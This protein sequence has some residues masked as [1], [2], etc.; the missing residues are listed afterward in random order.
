MSK[1]EWERLKAGT[2]AD[3]EVLKAMVKRAFLKSAE[4]VADIW[5][6]SDGA[7][8]KVRGFRGSFSPGNIFQVKFPTR[9]FKEDLEQYFRELMMYLPE[10]NGQEKPEPDWRGYVVSIEKDGD[11]ML[12]RSFL[13][14]LT[15]DELESVKDYLIRLVSRIDELLKEEVTG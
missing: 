6:R 10:P 3:T 4:E 8:V 2:I 15:R 1:R 12:M 13:G 7:F 14:G 11:V 9:Q 5:V